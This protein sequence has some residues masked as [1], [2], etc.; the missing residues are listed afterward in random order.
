MNNAMRFPF[1][2]TKNG[3][4]DVLPLLPI[5]LN[6][7]ENKLDVNASLDTGAMVSVLPWSVGEAL[8][9]VWE[10]QAIPLRLTGNLAN[11][12][13]RALLLSATVG[14]FP[15]VQLAFAWSK[16]DDVPILLGMTNFFME[17]DVCF[18][19]TQASFEIRP[20]SSR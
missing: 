12:E 10:K 11:I 13:A 17:F 4:A 3:V 2:T 15:A 1:T 14:L 6:Y 8:G 16:S 18:F 20:K 7:H 5:Q 19:R 9:V